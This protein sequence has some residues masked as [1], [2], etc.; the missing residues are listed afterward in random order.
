M[1]SYLLS[2]DGLSKSFRSSK[3]LSLVN[4]KIYEN[5]IVALIGE[6][7]SGKS[8][9][10]KILLGYFKTDSGEITYKYRRINKQRRIF[11]KI[12]GFVSQDNSFYENLTVV[13][14]LIFYSKMHNI[15]R[16]E[17]NYRVEYLLNLVD[18]RL[19]RNIICSKLSGGMKRRLEFAIAL[20]HDPKVII[21]D[22][23]FTGLDI[24]LR[25]ELWKV[26]EVIRGTGVTI[27]ISTHLLSYV[28][29]HCD[30]AL[31]LNN[32]SVEEIDNDMLKNMDLEEYMLKKINKN[33]FYHNY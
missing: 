26:L 18:L 30:R 3:I 8:T 22:E 1:E 27:I 6:S 21:L 9:L 28:Q 32:R 33:D 5:E 13:E 4:F 16:K 17:R 29:K 2:I 15:T 23:P 11:S 12:V 14:N 7:G 25:N 20:I 24:G 31:L 19:S 10:I